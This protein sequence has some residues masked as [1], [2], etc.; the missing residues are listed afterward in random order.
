MKSVSMFLVFMITIINIK[1]KLRT[2]TGKNLSNEGSQVSNNKKSSEELN[3]LSKNLNEFNKKNNNDNE[4]NSSTK[5]NFNNSNKIT[6][7][8]PK[9]YKYHETVENFRNLFNSKT[10][11]ENVCD[12]LSMSIFESV[13]SEDNKFNEV[14]FFNYFN[15]DL[16]SHYENFLLLLKQKEFSHKLNSSV[17]KVNVEENL[18]YRNYKN[19]IKSKNTNGLKFNKLFN[20]V[21]IED[22]ISLITKRSNAAL[23]AN[24]LI[25]KFRFGESKNNLKEQTETKNNLKLF[26][27]NQ[28][29]LFT[30]NSLYIQTD[31]NP[32]IS[33]NIDSIDVTRYPAQLSVILN[34][35]DQN[36]KTDKKINLIL[37]IYFSQNNNNNYLNNDNDLAAKFIGENDPMKLDLEFLKLLKEDLKNIVKLNITDL[38][39]AYKNKLNL[40]SLKYHKSNLT[41]IVN[42]DER[43]ANL[44]KL[45]LRKFNYTKNFGDNFIDSLE[46]VLNFI[47]KKQNDFNKSNDESE[48]KKILNKTMDNGL[49]FS[50]ISSI[51]ENPNTNFDVASIKAKGEREKDCELFYQIELI[52]VIPLTAKRLKS[53]KNYINELIKKYKAE[54]EKLFAENVNLIN[55]SS[56]LIED[57]AHKTSSFLK[58]GEDEP[59]LFIEEDNTIVQKNPLIKLLTEN[60]IKKAKLDLNNKKDRSFIF[61]LNFNN[62]EKPLSEEYK[63]FE[64]E[65][66]NLED[67]FSYLLSSNKIITT[68]SKNNDM[69]KM[70]D[71]FFFLITNISNKITKNI[72]FRDSPQIEEIEEENEELELEDDVNENEDE[73]K[74]SNET[75]ENGNEIIYRDDPA[76]VGNIEENQSEDIPHHKKHKKKHKKKKKNHKHHNERQSNQTVNNSTNVTNLSK[77]TTD[78]KQQQQLK[79]I[80]KVENKTAKNITAKE[81]HNK[82]DTTVKLEE[83]KEK[84]SNKNKSEHDAEKV[85]KKKHMKKHKKHHKNHTD[86]DNE[87]KTK[88]EV[89]LN[90]Y[91]SKKDHEKNENKN[92]SVASDALA[93]IVK[94]NILPVNENYKNNYIGSNSSKS[95]ESNNKEEL[96]HINEEK[97]KGKH[98]GKV[99]FEGLLKYLDAIKIVPVVAATQTKPKIESHF[100]KTNNITVIKPK[101]FGKENKTKTEIHSIAAVN[102]T[103][104]KNETGKAKIN[105]IIIITGNATHIIKNVSKIEPKSHT[106]NLTKPCNFSNLNTSLSNNISKSI[107][108][109][110]NLNSNKSLNNTCKNNKTLN[111]NSY[112]NTIKNSNV[113]SNNSNHNA[114]ENSLTNNNKT[115]STFNTEKKEPEINENI[116]PIEPN[117]YNI[118]NETEEENKTENSMNS[119]ENYLDEMQLN[120]TITT[121]IA[122]TANKSLEPESKNA[123]KLTKTNNSTSDSSDTKAEENSN[124]G[125]QTENNHNMNNNN[126]D[127]N[128]NINV[129]IIRTK[130]KKDEM[131]NS[132]VK[133]EDKNAI[134]F[135]ASDVN[136]NE[137]AKL[138]K[139]LLIPKDEFP[140]IDK[141][142]ATLIRFIP[143]ISR[144]QNLKIKGNDVIFDETIIFGDTD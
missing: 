88:P 30:L 82:L 110:P 3:S 136:K 14:C 65:I 85:K 90:N 31:S 96:K 72:V 89:K 70:L 35:F 52:D 45:L 94:N 133:K 100:N 9:D 124:S 134:V 106:T 46:S 32:I 57:K 67:S 128:I 21:V 80:A 44:K 77:I 17:K 99:N 98:D 108:T 58:A 120:K 60:K 36:G 16:N 118:N 93:S 130:S 144:K 122:S 56:E 95:N 73:T 132:V 75:E 19:I 121:I 92:H 40:G 113:T 63:K 69:I 28:E 114:N 115:T 29:I 24:D 109:K 13:F 15:T 43:I 64:S 5:I 6:D 26:F 103:V 119:L 33:K 50:V 138:E 81:D 101:S 7:K 126:K 18:F 61:P 102:K 51:L 23:T 78:F 137:V 135:N 11:A 53:F 140:V 39:D 25:I 41:D 125:E 27:N 107:I 86:H 38:T 76:A 127:H 105:K 112:N 129:N 68:K 104:L 74:E 83:H 8:S 54:N 22:K 123:I 12:N 143:K 62:F 91:S 42:L 117:N 10:D 139:D 37:N 20:N 97:K 55:R 87:N 49:D 4:S 141:G 116:S 47:V 59:L 66:N 71:N 131:E 2:F 79:P 142:N 34:G 111:N 84:D 1:S 48:K